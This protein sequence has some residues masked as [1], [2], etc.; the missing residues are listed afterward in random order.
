[1]YP[2]S[3]SDFS[4]I[5][6]NT[7][8]NNINKNWGQF[9]KNGELCIHSLFGSNSR[10]ERMLLRPQQTQAYAEFYCWMHPHKKE[11]K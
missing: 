4:K 9:I 10:M 8:I 3:F 5:I 6:R 1:M 11:V 7:I 2:F